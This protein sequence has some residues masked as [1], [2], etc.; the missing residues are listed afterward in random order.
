[1]VARLQDRKQAAV[2]LAERI[3]IRDV[4]IAIRKV[5]KR[6]AKALKELAGM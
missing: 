5:E 4:K 1:M 2:Q 3:Q 6:Y